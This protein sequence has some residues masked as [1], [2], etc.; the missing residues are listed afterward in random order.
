[1][2][3]K[4]LFNFPSDIDLPLDFEE[5]SGKVKLSLNGVSSDWI[6]GDDLFLKRI[7]YENLNPERIEEHLS[8]EIRMKNRLDEGKSL[9]K[10]EK[11]KKAIECFDDVIYYDEG[12]GEAVMNKSHALYGQRHFVKALRHYRKAVKAG[13]IQDN[14]Y[15]KLLLDE[16]RKERD[17]FPKIKL[18]IYAGDECFSKGDY[19]GAVTCYDKALDD[20]SKFREKILSKLLNKKATALFRLGEFSQSLD[21]FEESLKVKEN[22]CAYFGKG[23]SLYRLSM[24]NPKSQACESCLDRIYVDAIRDCLKKAIKISKR[25]LIIKADILFELHCREA[26]MYYEEFLKNHFKEDND[27]LKAVSAIELLKC[28]IHP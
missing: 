24:E 7:R 3:P 13:C 18:N 6:D 2:N 19:A 10:R 8:Y 4:D 23:Y 25:Q 16:S 5:S 17:S 21:I 22:D 11:Y 9:L 15:Y 1:M 14:I 28:A 12:Y 20:S 27:Y 26:L